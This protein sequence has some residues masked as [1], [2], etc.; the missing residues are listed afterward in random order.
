MFGNKIFSVL[1]LIFHTPINLACLSDSK[2][3]SK[4]QYSD[5][6]SSQFDYKLHTT[7]LRGPI[8]THSFGLRK[9]LKERWAPSQFINGSTPN[10]SQTVSAE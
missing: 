5:L 7:D 8:V 4:R 6:Y 9:P 2:N 3:T 10:R 1:L